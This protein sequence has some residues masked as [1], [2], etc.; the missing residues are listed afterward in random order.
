M[1]W[2]AVSLVVFA[3]VTPGASASSALVIGFDLPWSAATIDCIAF[4]DLET[5]SSDGARTPLRPEIREFAFEGHKF[6][7]AIDNGLLGP[8]N[9]PLVRVWTYLWDEL[10][11]EWRCSHHVRFAQL[12]SV[13]CELDET[14]GWLRIAG[15]GNDQFRGET[16]AA[17]DLLAVLRP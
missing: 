2:I 10:S 11:G 8:S 17:V 15:R 3:I 14:T 6:V 4:A 16:V 12:F 9:R 5:V 1:N 7:A 13:G